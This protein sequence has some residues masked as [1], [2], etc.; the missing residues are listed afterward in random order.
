MGGLLT[1]SGP[2]SKDEAKT[3]AGASQMSPA[4]LHLYVAEHTSGLLGLTPVG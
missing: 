2:S 4:I 1:G 3:P